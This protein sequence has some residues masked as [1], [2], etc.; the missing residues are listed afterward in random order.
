MLFIFVSAFIVL[1]L[2]LCLSENLYLPVLF[3]ALITL[4]LIFKFHVFSMLL[5]GSIVLIYFFAYHLM[6][7]A[8]LKKHQ[9]NYPLMI[10]VLV[11]LVLGKI[12]MMPIDV[13]GMVGVVLIVFSSILLNTGKM[14]T[15]NI[16][17]PILG[18]SG[19]LLIIY[20]LMQKFNLSSFVLECIFASISLIGLIRLIIKYQQN[21]QIPEH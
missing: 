21:K 14:S 1:I 13:Y 7:T 12:N 6:N 18:F 11:I 3:T 10:T 8:R 4:F 15:E 16:N 17:Y 19:S 5:L 2:I 20:T 9:P